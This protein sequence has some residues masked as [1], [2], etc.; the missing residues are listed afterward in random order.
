MTLHIAHLPH[1]SRLQ[2]VVR[3]VAG[4]WYIMLPHALPLAVLAVVSVVLMPVAWVAILV[5]GR[6]PKALFAYEVGLLSW[7]MRVNA[8]LLNLVDGYPAFGLQATDAHVALVI[9]M[10]HHLNRGHL[11]LKLL[12]GWA[13]CGIPHGAVLLLRGMVG[14]VVMTLAF[15]TVLVAGRYPQAWHAFMVSTLRHS[16]AVRLYMGGMTDHY[17]AFS[18]RA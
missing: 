5:S 11:L 1:Y 17:P 10:P 8:R 4:V 7:Q 6:Y 2:L 9:P 18:G 3:M 16:L 13:Y 14:L 12:L 15:C